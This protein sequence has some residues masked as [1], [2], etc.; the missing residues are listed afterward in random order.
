MA[1]DISIR[2]AN[3]ADIEVLAEFNMAMA[4]ETEGKVL[5]ADVIRA[6]VGA[7]FENPQ[8]GFYSMA[9]VADR[10]AAALMIT[11]EW[12]DWRN[13]LFWWIQ[14]VYVKPDYRRAGVF[15]RL[16]QSIRDQAIARPD[17]CGLRLYVERENVA[18]QQT[19]L[20][21]GMVETAYRLFEEEF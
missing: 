13:G 19:Y 21:M 4:L 9:L 18:A 2:G 10:P 17:V 5:P 20:K 14:S 15:R 1:A 11:T 16:Y 6:G 7:L 3:T 12:S 8:L